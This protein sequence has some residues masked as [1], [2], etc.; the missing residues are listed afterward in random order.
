MCL[1][2][3][4]LKNCSSNYVMRTPTSSILVDVFYLHTNICVCRK[5]FG[6]GN[7]VHVGFPSHCE[8]LA[9]QWAEFVVSR[10][11]RAG[12]L[13]LLQAEPVKNNF[14]SEVKKKCT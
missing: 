6:H 14:L 4:S 9:E 13:V 11:S 3:P 7:P 1:T 10:R 2:A 12:T 8:A 5:E